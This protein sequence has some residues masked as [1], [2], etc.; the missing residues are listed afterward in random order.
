[1]TLVWQEPPTSRNR[2]LDGYTDDARQL[3]TRP[4]KWA[5]VTNPDGKVN[6]AK[7]VKEGEG[8]FA[9]KGD[10]EARRYDTDSGTEYYVRYVERKPA[11]DEMRSAMS[12]PAKPTDAPFQAPDADTW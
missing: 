2:L 10:F 9:P 12:P 5:K 6:L 1:M 3:R 11:S 4:G 8:P 7:A